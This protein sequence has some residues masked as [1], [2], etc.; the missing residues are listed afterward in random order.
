MAG[1]RTIVINKRCKL[2]SRLGYLVIRTIEESRVYIQEIENLII[3]STAVSLTSALLADLVSAGVN[4]VF[5]NSEHLPHSTCI[6]ISF[7]YNSPKKINIQFKWNEE[8][9]KSCWQKIVKEK[10]KQQAFV[11]N[12]VNK[13]EAESSLLEYCERVLPGDTD[14]MEAI[15]A[16]CYFTALFGDYFSRSK[17]NNIE[18]SA[19]NY[20]YSILLSCFSREIVA[21]G[22]LTELGIWHRGQENSYNL[23]CDLMEPFRPLVDL[24]VYDMPISEEN[25]FRHYMINILNRKVLIDN[26]LQN[27]VYAIR[28]YTR[29]V[30]KYLNSE[31]SSLYDIQFFREE[32]TDM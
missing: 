13:Q 21:C 6:P 8:L 27:L 28:L 24:H 5:C 11:L 2:E 26:E 14:N 12:Q 7:H 22:Y 31:T 18:N 17:S 16:K 19:L 25:N 1:F 10:I 29:K 3:E 23:A 4:V 20:G 32:T 15:A 30:L 9:K